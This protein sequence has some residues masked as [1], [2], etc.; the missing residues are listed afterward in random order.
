MRRKGT[1]ILPEDHRG[2]NRN[3]ELPCGVHGI[4]SNGNYYAGFLASLCCEIG[5]SLVR[6]GQIDG[7]QLHGRTKAGSEPLRRLFENIHFRV[8]DHH[9]R[10]RFSAQG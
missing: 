9:D 8:S 6:G 4:V 5:G 7:N 2:Y 10:G 3:A 1:E